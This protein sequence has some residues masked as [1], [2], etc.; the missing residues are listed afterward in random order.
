MRERS[1]DHKGESRVI[2]DYDQEEAGFESS[3]DIKVHIVAIE[4]VK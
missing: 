1:P 2:R 4:M 3:G